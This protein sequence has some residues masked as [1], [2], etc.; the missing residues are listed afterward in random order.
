[1]YSLVGGAEIPADVVWI[2]VR[3]AEEY[4][5]GHLAGATFI[6]HDEIE[7]GVAQLNLARDTPIYLYC[8]SG[9]RAGVVKETLQAA[10]YT[11]VTNI[12]GLDDAQK[13]ATG[14]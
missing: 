12:G 6:P 1:M 3:T 7:K 8:R 14:E 9:N 2:D 11:N 10:H 13:L 4:Q 5:E